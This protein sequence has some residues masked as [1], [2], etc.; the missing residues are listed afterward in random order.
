MENNAYNIFNTVIRLNNII[1]NLSVPSASNVFTYMPTDEDNK[2]I[3]FNNKIVETEQDKNNNYVIKNPEEICQVICYSDRFKYIVVRYIPQTDSSVIKYTV[4]YDKITKKTKY[5]IYNIS[6]Q[7]KIAFFNIELGYISKIEQKSQFQPFYNFT[8]NSFNSILSKHIIES[9]IEKTLSFTIGANGQVEIDS[10][11]GFENNENR[12]FV[13]KITHLEN[14]S[15]INNRWKIGDFGISQEDLYI[16]LVASKFNLPNNIN[17]NDY[18]KRL[19]LIDWQKNDRYNVKYLTKI[20][21][22]Q[23]I[24][25]RDLQLCANCIIPL[26][27]D[28]HVSLL[29]TDNNNAIYQYDSRGDSGRDELSKINNLCTNDRKQRGECCGYSVQGFVLHNINHID[30]KHL[31]D[32]DKIINR[33]INEYL[34]NSKYIDITQNIKKII[35]N[36]AVLDSKIRDNSISCYEAKHLYYESCYLL[37]YSFQS[38]SYNRL[39]VQDA[40]NK[41]VFVNFNRCKM[42]K[43]IRQEHQNK[44]KHTNPRE[45]KTEQTLSEFM[46]KKLTDSIL[47]IYKNND[48]KHNDI[49]LEEYS[50]LVKNDAALNNNCKLLIDLQHSQLILPQDGQR[51]INN[52]YQQ[53]NTSAEINLI[54]EYK[55]EK[56]NNIMQQK[57][58]QQKNEVMQIKDPN[59]TDKEREHLNNTFNN[60]R[61]NIALDIAMAKHTST[62]ETQQ[63]TKEQGI[64]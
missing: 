46:V 35:S 43:D 58:I 54:Q 25:R 22:K 2:S 49:Y 3:M 33:K 4:V 52:N 12:Q 32:N 36:K 9:T 38:R 19:R 11:Y 23:D 18:L 21:N 48:L 7:D 37:Q 1:F 28:K 60:I 13:K 34:R 51:E 53:L 29:I 26:T 17:D 59:L 57:H 55:S 40:E 31:Q 24:L 5:T 10:I 6:K 62:K 56:Q 27:Y 20:N 16:S 45:L 8:N 44:I 39:N 64:L 50:Q 30:V 41:A 61:D 42:L 14:L 47:S 15:K 63:N